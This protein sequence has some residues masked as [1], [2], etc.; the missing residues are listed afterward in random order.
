MAHFPR[1]CW[2]LSA[3]TARAVLA[4]ARRIRPLSARFVEVRLDYLTNPEQGPQIIKALGRSRIPAIAT[5]RS[6]AAGG[7]YPGSLEGQLRILQACATAGASIVDLE[8]E[9]AEQAGPAAV[10]GLGRDARLLLSF[11]D[12]KQTPEPLEAV[13]SRLKVFPADFYKIVARSWS[14]D[15]NAAL[16]RLNGGSRGNG[17]VLAFALDELGQPTR[18]LSVARG[19]PFTYGALASEQ[20]VAPGQ[21]TGQELLE[22]YRLGRLSGRTAVYGIIGNPVAHSLSPVVHNAAFAARRRDAVYLPFRVESLEDFLEA[23]ETYRLA[24]FSITLPHKEAMAYAAGWVDPEAR[25]VGAINTIVR[26]GRKLLGYNTD[27]AG[28]VVPLEKRLRLAGARVLVA[29][30]GGAARAVA[31]AVARRKARVVVVARRAEQAAELAE[32]VGGEVVERNVLSREQFD[33]IVHA[34]PLGMHPATDDCFFSQGELNARVVFDTVYNPIET[35]L[36]R[37]ARKRRVQVIAGMEMFLEQAVRQFE[38][39][40]GEK[41]PRLVMQRAAFGAL[42]GK[43]SWS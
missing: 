21:L 42:G 32:E 2:T 6:A 17:K 33:A 35:K 23:L 31:F 9:S 24:G 22:R 4:S 7:R 37:M 40:T 13:L 15:K 1:V 14:H 26:R 41:A 10:A 29:G 36:L 11:H 34:T 30:A 19:A 39:W 5:L 28:I 25:E 43:P 8:I 3:A 38:L 18:V 20:A 16:L 12:Y 27:G